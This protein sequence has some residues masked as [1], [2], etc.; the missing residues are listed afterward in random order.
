MTMK[1]LQVATCL[2][3]VV[4]AL[5]A[6]RVR[7]DDWPGWRGLHRDGISNEKG[8][9]EK[10]PKKG[11]RLKWIAR[12]AGIGYSSFAVKGG[13]LFTMG[14]RKDKREY[15]AAY[16]AQSG[17]ELWA[18]PLGKSFKQGRGDGPRGTPTI[19]GPWLYA[20]GASGELVCLDARTGEERWGFN[21]LKKFGG[22]NINWGLSESP[23]VV[24][25]LLIVSPGARDSAVVALKKDNGDVVWKS[26]GERPGYASPILVEYGPTRQVVVFN[27]SAAVGVNLE[28]GKRLWTYT[29]ASNGTA[30]CTTP[31][32]HDGHVFVT[33]DYGTGGG[34]VRL[35]PKGRGRVDSSEVYFTRDM[36]NHHGGV[37][38][39]DGYLYGFSSSILTCLDFKS[40]ERMWRNRSVGKG[41]LMYADGHLY[42]LSE[43]GVVGLVVATPDRYREKSRFSIGKSR[44]PTWAHPV[45]A[46]GALYLRKDGE[47]RCY[48]VRGKS[49]ES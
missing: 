22:R 29:S 27:S 49:A 23:L 15:V 2:C 3:L 7:G 14:N 9:L 26:P 1:T 13:R 46:N 5:S 32:Y 30:N 8:L 38:L 31:V 19:D 28:N 33:S 17:K 11:P 42:C 41:S 47:I 48:D 6:P 21:I 39:V 10:W 12:S 34:L 16:D 44:K 20:E 40:G 45:L 35:A 25:D 4:S 43:K 24:E 18:H 36:K 37:V